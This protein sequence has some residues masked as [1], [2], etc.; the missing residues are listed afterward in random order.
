[1]RCICHSFYTT[2]YLQ[3]KDIKRC[4]LLDSRLATHLFSPPCR[5]KMLQNFIAWNMNELKFGFKQFL[6]WLCNKKPL[7]SSINMVRLD[8]LENAYN[9]F[10]WAHVKATPRTLRMLVKTILK[11]QKVNKTDCHQFYSLVW[12]QNLVRLASSTSTTE[13]CL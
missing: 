5:T 13:G 10:S 8:E 1:M 11:Y 9:C 3:C 12:S 4:S 2:Y 7:L 6:N